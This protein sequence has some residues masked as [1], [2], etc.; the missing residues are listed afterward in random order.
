MLL[1]AMQNM[2][3]VLENELNSDNTMRNTNDSF[4]QLTFDKQLSNDEADE[5]D[6]DDNQI[7]PFGNG[8]LPFVPLKVIQLPV[9]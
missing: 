3:L 4:N 9:V 5:N 8:H 6:L 2:F 1:L 7:P